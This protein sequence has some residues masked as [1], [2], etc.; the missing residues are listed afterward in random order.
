M[1]ERLVELLVGRP[2][3]ETEVPP[4]IE[5]IPANWIEWLERIDRDE[6]WAGALDVARRGALEWSVED[7]LA[8]PHAVDRLSGLLVSSGGSA[9]VQNAL[10]HLLTFFERDTRWPRPEFASV[11][12]VALEVLAIG[13]EGGDDDVRVYARLA[14]AVLELGVN[15]KAY[16]DLIAGARHLLNSFTSPGRVQWGLQLVEA[17]VVYP[18]PDEAKRQQ[19]LQD[20]VTLVRKFW[21]RTDEGTR[22]ALRLL[23]QDLAQRE[24]LPELT[25]PPPS[26]AAVAPPNV[27]AMLN[28][29]SVAIYTLTERTGHFMRQILAEQAPQAVVHLSHDKVGNERLRSMARRADIFIMATGSAKHA[30]T[31]FIEHHRPGDRPLL[32]PVGKGV[33]SML[34]VLE[35]FLRSIPDDDLPLAS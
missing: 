5:A 23:C 10:P 4:P 9:T 32:R 26:A 15:S 21:R 19:L 11:Y 24:L 14:E 31:E 1:Y 8:V 20:V 17:T 30:A 7:L 18:C 12:T 13:S 29:K 6:H 33:G 35:D 34:Q 25:T 2:P 16:D 27:L 3:V 22:A 28:G